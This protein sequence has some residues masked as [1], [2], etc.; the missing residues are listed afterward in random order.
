MTYLMILLLQGRES[1]LGVCVVMASPAPSE[2]HHWTDFSFGLSRV[3]ALQV[4]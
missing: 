1:D 4:Y 3:Y 2:R